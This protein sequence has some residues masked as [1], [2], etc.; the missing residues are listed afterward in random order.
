MAV[1]DSTNEVTV[2]RLYSVITGLWDKI[3]TGFG[4]KADKVSNATNGHFAG[5]DANGNLTDSGSKAS[6]FKT[7][8]TAVQFNGSS[9]KTVKKIEQNENGVVSVEFENIYL[10]QWIP[11]TCNPYD[12]SIELSI[13]NAGVRNGFLNFNGTVRKLNGNFTTNAVNS[14]FTVEG[15]ALMMDFRNY[16]GSAGLNSSTDLFPCAMAGLRG[17]NFF[18][19]YPTKEC[20][21]FFFN[22][23][24]PVDFIV[25]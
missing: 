24:V 16:Y 10:N 15:I 8:Q 19:I 6:D 25:K 11:I 2:R 18:Y 1:S 12:S 14:I 21:L 7:K 20:N 23:T 5:L 9:T 13:I 3:T 17:S 22:G 4:N